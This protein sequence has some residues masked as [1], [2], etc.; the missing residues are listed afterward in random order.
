[1]STVTTRSLDLENH[2]RR[3]SPM[4]QESIEIHY[5]NATNY[6]SEGLHSPT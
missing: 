6:A 1:M 5:V 2:V 3:M 4:T